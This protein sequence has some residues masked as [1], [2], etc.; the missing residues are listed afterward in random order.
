MPHRFAKADGIRDDDVIFTSKIYRMGGDGHKRN[1]GPMI[2]SD[3]GM[4]KKACFCNSVFKPTRQRLFVV[5]KSVNRRIG[6]HFREELKDALGSAKLVQIIVSESYF[7]L[8]GKWH[9]P[10]VSADFDLCFLIFMV[11]AVHIVPKFMTG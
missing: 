7:H 4:I 1:K 3:K 2:F 11:G 10:V 5:K 8:G 9:M 6:I